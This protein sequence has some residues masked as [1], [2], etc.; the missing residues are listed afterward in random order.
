MMMVVLR[1]D[2]P[3]NNA[4]G[5]ALAKTLRP[6]TTFC[7]KTQNRSVGCSAM[8]VAKINVGKWFGRPL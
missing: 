4:G 6:L 7:S 1:C 3:D 5:A 8:V 2:W